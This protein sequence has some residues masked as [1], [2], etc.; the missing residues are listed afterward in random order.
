[1]VTET[2]VSTETVR[3]GRLWFGFAASAGAWLVLGFI[4]LLMVWL[5]CAYEEEYTQLATHPYAR[6]A[7]LILAVVSLAVAVTAGVTSFRSWRALSQDRR[8]IDAA[9]DGRREFM[10]FLGVIVSIT[11]G[12]GIVWLSLPPLIIHFCARTK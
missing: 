7:C 10:A 2:R 3:P 5:E 12:A 1:M 6:V 8:F 4:D 9:A 11:L